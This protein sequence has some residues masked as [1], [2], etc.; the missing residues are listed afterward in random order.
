MAFEGKS[1]LLSSGP[2]SVVLCWTNLR[3][4][5]S[6]VRTLWVER[7]WGRGQGCHITMQQNDFSN[8]NYVLDRLEMFKTK[9]T[10]IHAVHILQKM[11]FFVKSGNPSFLD[12]AASLADGLW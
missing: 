3:A 2:S 11:N 10:R 6:R 12:G 1:D 9:S 7:V 4:R 5:P 8:Y